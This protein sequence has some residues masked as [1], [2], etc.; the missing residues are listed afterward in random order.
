MLGSASL[1][2]LANYYSPLNAALSIHKEE[3]LKLA[4][5]FITIFLCSSLWASELTTV[6]GIQSSIEDN[7]S[8]GASKEDIEA[9]LTS[10][11]LSHSYDQY[12]F[13]YQAIVRENEAQCKFEGV[14]L[15]LFYDCAIQIFINLNENG[16]YKSHEVSHSY[17]GL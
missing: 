12:S 8:V 14:F 3:A 10:A 16:T 6:E 1:H 11:N 9:Y 17:T 15:W 7:L 2:I 5:A 13:R 4:I